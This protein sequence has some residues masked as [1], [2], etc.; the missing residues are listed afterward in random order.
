MIFTSMIS[1]LATL[2]LASSV[3][4]FNGPPPVGPRDKGDGSVSFLNRIV[5]VYPIPFVEFL[6]PDGC[7]QPS[8]EQITI[9]LSCGL[10]AQRLSAYFGLQL[11]RN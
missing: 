10:A 4:A 11:E 8:I 6:T 3:M 9:C 7:N 1:K 5:L 2:A